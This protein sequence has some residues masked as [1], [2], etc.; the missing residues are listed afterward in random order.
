MSL[1]PIVKIAGS[2]VTMLLLA[3]CGAFLGDQ[4][5]AYFV[6]NS[7]ELNEA[8]QNAAS[9]DVIILEANEYG[10]LEVPNKELEE[11]ISIVSDKEGEARFER[12]EIEDCEDVEVEGVE[13]ESYPSMAAMNVEMNTLFECDQE[14]E[15][16]EA[17]TDREEAREPQNDEEGERDRER[18]EPEER[19]RENGESDEQEPEND[20]NLER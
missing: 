17:E 3:N 16:R 1:K 19:E 14:D 15:K 6:S 7:E 12:I 4:Q 2:V 10:E 9:G 11:P 18:D 13:V 8:L 20:D 5:S